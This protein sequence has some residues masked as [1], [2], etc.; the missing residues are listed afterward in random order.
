MRTAASIRAFDVGATA[1]PQ[2]VGFLLIPGFALLAYASAVEPLRAANRLS[3]RNLYEWCHISPD[4]AVVSASC[5]LG[6]NVDHR[7][8]ADVDLD[9]LFVVSGGNPFQF[10]HAQTFAWLRSLARRGARLGG[11]SGGPVILARAN[12]LSGYRCT[13]HWEHVPA[14]R[15]T[16]PNLQLTCNLF[17]IDGSRLT[18]AGATAALD[19][20][21]ALIVSQHGES[22]GAAVSDWFLQTQVRASSDQQ[23]L[24]LRERFGVSDSKLLRVLEMME[25]EVEEP[26]LRSQLALE[27]GISIR[28]LERLFRAHLNTSLTAH[29]KKIRLMRA[30]LL[31]GQTSL[32]VIAIG[33]ACGFLS[34]SH[35]SQSYNARFGYPPRVERSSASLKANRRR[36][37]AS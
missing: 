25:R 20:M 24:S 15:E 29:Y 34:A 27:V 36:K 4:D 35:F 14:F 17:E 1:K 5:G 6:I 19:M 13:V 26:I 7:V 10:N 21:H 28:Q 30:Q 2:K 8:G 11:I 37:S 32:P 12:L 23:R 16:F 9:I 31:L 18:C 33:I 3:G 22:L